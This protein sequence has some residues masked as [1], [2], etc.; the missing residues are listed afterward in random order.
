MSELELTAD[1]DCDAAS[2]PGCPRCGYD[3]SGL[4]ASWEGGDR[5]PLRGVC[6]ECGFEFDWGRVLNSE[7]Y[8]LPWLYEHAPG[9]RPMV[10]RAWRTW[11]RVILPWRFWRE[12]DGVRLDTPHNWWR[13]SAWLPV[14]TGSVWAVAGTFQVCE[15]LLYVL[16]SAPR[17]M[18]RVQ[19]RN[20]RWWLEA[21]FNSYFEQ[22]VS[23]NARWAGGSVIAP[24]EVPYQLTA[25][26][27]CA[28][29]MPL[30]LLLG[31]TRAIVKVRAAHIARAS[32]YGLAPVILYPLDWFL[33]RTLLRLDVVQSWWAWII[34]TTKI[35]DLMPVVFGLCGIAWFGLWWWVVLVRVFAL[36]SGRAVWLL[37]TT[38]CLLA[39]ASA[40]LVDQRFVW[41]MLQ[42]RRW[43][44]L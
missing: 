21:I 20:P 43:L 8:K 31:T 42:I 13:L 35:Y 5:C 16:T 41:D 34:N 29:V 24:R 28:A 15:W 1:D 26:L 39:S 18:I 25:W 17:S 19:V 3:Q 38:A 14:I 6:S 44:G 11:Q 27:V 30:M 4:R 2:P 32:I 12:S 40:V 10:R 22:V 7:K 33:H 36:P 23:L 37:L 9:R